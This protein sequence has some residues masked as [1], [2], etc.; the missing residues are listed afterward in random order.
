MLRLRQTSCELETVK[1]LLIY[2]LIKLSNL[3]FPHCEPDKGHIL[4]T[5]SYL[6]FSLCFFIKPNHIQTLISK[7]DINHLCFPSTFHIFLPN[8]Y[9]RNVILTPNLTEK[10]HCLLTQP[11]SHIVHT[12][13]SCSLGLVVVVVVSVLAK[14]CN[15]GGKRGGVGAAVWNAVS[16]EGGWVEGYPHPNFYSNSSLRHLCLQDG[17]CTN[18]WLE[19]EKHLGPNDFLEKN[20]HLIG[21]TMVTVKNG[22][23]LLSGMKVPWETRY[24]ENWLSPW[25]HLIYL[26]SKQSRLANMMWFWRSELWCGLYFEYRVQAGWQ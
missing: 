6:I 18:Y 12:P 14:L 23:R 19:W 10:P 21:A 17:I 8:N 2:C 15:V 5:M 16:L 26:F 1:S 22:W 9:L 3:K 13:A 24:E 11:P 4:R 7:W 20:R 25:V